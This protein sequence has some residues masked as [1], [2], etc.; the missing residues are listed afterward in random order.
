MSADKVILTEEYLFSHLMRIKFEMEDRFNVQITDL[1]TH[2]HILKEEIKKII[3]YTE[4]LSEN[5]DAALMKVHTHEEFISTIKN[6]E[7]ELIEEIKERRE[8]NG[9]N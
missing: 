8:E 7:F 2:N 3:K 9:R 1:I 6:V 4:Y 5:L